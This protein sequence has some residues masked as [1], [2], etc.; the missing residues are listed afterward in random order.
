MAGSGAGADA[1][2]L[3]KGTSYV[4]RSFNLSAYAGQTVTVRFVGTED[5]SLAT[6]FVIDDTGGHDELTTG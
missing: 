4:Q 1:A 6:S 2:N 5:A 3:N